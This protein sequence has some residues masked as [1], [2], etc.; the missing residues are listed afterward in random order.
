MI[1][2]SWR[3]ELYEGAADADVTTGE[4]AAA[5]DAKYRQEVAYEVFSRSK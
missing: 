5:L 3:L 1:N 2:L 4:A